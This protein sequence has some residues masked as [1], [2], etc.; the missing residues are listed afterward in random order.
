MVDGPVAKIVIAL[1]EQAHLRVLAMPS[2]NTTGA[3][4]G[5]N[6]PTHRRRAQQPARIIA[7]I[8]DDTGDPVSS[9]RKSRLN[10]ATRLS[11]VWTWNCDSDIGVA[12]SIS[13]PRRCGRGSGTRQVEP[14]AVSSLR[15]T[16]SARLV[17][18][19]PAHLSDDLLQALTLVPSGRRP[20]RSRRPASSRQRRG[21]ALEHRHH[22]DAA[23]LQ[24]DLEAEATVLAAVLVVELAERLGVEIDRM[25]GRGCAA[26]R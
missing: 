21:P 6:T 7:Q 19:L 11:G 3:P 15:T 5:R 16:V 10:P 24:R 20:R 4:A 9:C 26:P 14:S 12:G 8:Q 22:L 18:A 2:V 17:A 13:S 25:R 1:R 23:F